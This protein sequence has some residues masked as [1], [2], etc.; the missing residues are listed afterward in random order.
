MYTEIFCQGIL[1]SWN[2]CTQ[3]EALFLAVCHFPIQIQEK[4]LVILQV[5]IKLLK[6]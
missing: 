4:V 5:D 3:F 2:M 1:S 6:I